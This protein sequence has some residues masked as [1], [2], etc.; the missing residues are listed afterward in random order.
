MSGSPDNIATQG[1]IEE[2]NTES[3]QE[4][5]KQEQRDLEATIEHRSST[6]DFKMTKKTHINISLRI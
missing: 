5:K 3:N 1:N 2:S 4:M 6:V